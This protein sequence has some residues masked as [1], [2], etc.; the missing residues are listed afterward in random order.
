[1]SLARPTRAHAVKRGEAMILFAVA[2]Y[3][4]AISAA[5]VDEIRSATSLEPF[6]PSPRVRVPTVRYTMTR[7]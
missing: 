1:M 5:A 2:S 6:T 7:Q 3:L 4:F